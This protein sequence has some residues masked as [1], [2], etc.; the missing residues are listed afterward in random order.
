MNYI[1]IM[2]VFI[3]LVDHSRGIIQ[4]EI[5]FLEI[6]TERDHVHFL[7]QSV[8]P[9]SPQKI[10]QTVQSITAQEIFKKLPSVKE[11]LWKGEFWSKYYFISTVR[12]T[13]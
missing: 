3:G 7:I 10:A 2:K 1:S 4:D 13:W 5:M 11:Q 9:Y 8:P 6:G 12:K